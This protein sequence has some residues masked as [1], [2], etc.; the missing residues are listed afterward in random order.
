M[1]DPRL[2][3]A[4]VKYAFTIA[5]HPLRRAKKCIAMAF[6]PQNPD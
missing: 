5:G 4:A 2:I 1:T 3:M 6:F